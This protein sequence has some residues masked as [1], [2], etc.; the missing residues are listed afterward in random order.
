MGY[1]SSLK[2]LRKFRGLKNQLADSFLFICPLGK[3]SRL[4][5]FATSVDNKNERSNLAAI[6]SLER[7]TLLWCTDESIC[8]K[9][10]KFLVLG[11]IRRDHSETLVHLS[12]ESLHHQLGLEIQKIGHSNIIW[13]SSRH[14]NTRLLWDYLKKLNKLEEEKGSH[15]IVGARNSLWSGN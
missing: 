15:A 2:L 11:K 12:S 5:C 7:G 1:K 3:T 13:L 4:W 10:H 6:Y 9:E 14:L 8:E